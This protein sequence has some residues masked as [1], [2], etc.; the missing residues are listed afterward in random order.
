[1]MSNLLV[2]V[3]LSVPLVYLSWRSMFSLR[4]HGFYRLIVWEC[5]LWLGIQNHQY[6]VGG[7][8]DLSLTPATFLTLGS[9][10]IVIWALATMYRHGQVSQQ[11]H[12]STLFEFE[13]TTELVDKGLFRYIRHPMYTSLLCLMWG[14]FWRQP[15]WPLLAVALLGSFACYM[16]ALIEER[17]N[18]EFFGEK[19]Q[20]YMRSTKRFVPF[21]Y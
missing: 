16:A 1:M 15:T 13:K 6:E 12:D 5:A 10:I 21:V 19:Y 2:F 9:L 8:V 18:L 20:E 7:G 17:E 4:N 14:F 11:R 3:L